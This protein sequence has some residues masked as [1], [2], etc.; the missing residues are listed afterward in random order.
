MRATAWTTFALFAPALL[1]LS[2]LEASVAT[3]ADEEPASGATLYTRYCS[4]CHGI[5]GRGDTELARLFKAPPPD[6][7]G[8]ARRQGGW[9]PAE[10]VQEIIDGRFTAHGQSHMPVWGLTLSAEQIARITEHLHSLQDTRSS[11]EP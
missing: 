11:A 4:S 3:A 10:I 9:F 5:D 8:I 1:L 6:L 7:R 2:A